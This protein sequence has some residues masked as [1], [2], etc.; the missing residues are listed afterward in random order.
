[1]HKK[2]IEYVNFK[3]RNDESSD[4][5]DKKAEIIANTIDRYDELFEKYHDEEYAYIEAIKSIGEVLGEE[6]EETTYRPE[7]AEMFLIS[8]TVLAIISLITTFL[9]GIAGIILL[10]ISITLYAVGAVYLY[11]AS[12]FAK[13][14]EYDISKYQLFLDKCFSY[15]KTNFTFWAL[16]L[17]ILLTKIIY[18]IFMYIATISSINSISIA[19]FQSIVIFSVISFIII[20]LII[21]LIFVVLYRK[22]MQK[23]TALSGNKD[24]QSVGKKVKLF[25]N[26]GTKDKPNLFQNKWFYTIINIIV[27]IFVV[28]DIIVTTNSYNYLYTNIVIF[29]VVFNFVI[30][31]AYAVVTT[32]HFNHQFKNSF[33]VPIFNIVMSILVFTVW[34][35]FDDIHYTLCS[36]GPIFFFFGIISIFLFFIDYLLNRKVK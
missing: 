33:F 36:N 24:I 3:L 12:K 1:M 35:S 7:F 6:T 9:S 30:L 11:Q 34:M 21:C 18:S 28:I 23:Y 25:L 20:F 4:I 32:R 19:D 22:L 13:T 31:F 15:M 5:Q 17:S 29:T 2:I 14:E 8:A 26:K 27:M 10:G 16:T